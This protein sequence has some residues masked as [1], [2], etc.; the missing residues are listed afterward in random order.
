[1]IKSKEEKLKELQLYLCKE[2]NPKR[3]G[4]CDGYIYS[5]IIT[6]IQFELFIRTE[7]IG[8]KYPIPN[9]DHLKTQN[10]SGLI[11]NLNLEFKLRTYNTTVKN[12]YSIWELDTTN[13]S[14]SDIKDLIQF[15]QNNY[16]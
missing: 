12:K 4:L 10:L 6:K 7:S 13:M 2:I 16:L 15:I 9:I 5:H 1:M 14:N 11:A 3:F 8:L